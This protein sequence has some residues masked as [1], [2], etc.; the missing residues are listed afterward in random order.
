MTK[1]R[2]S[3]RESSEC[4]QLIHA[5]GLV[6]PLEGMMDPREAGAAMRVRFYLDESAQK[7][8]DN[9]N[10]ARVVRAGLCSGPSSS[11]YILKLCN[12]STIT[13][14]WAALQSIRSIPFLDSLLRA[15]TVNNSARCV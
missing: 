2:L 5:L 9:V 15:K 11:W 14:E 7:G 8:P 1:D 3:S 10:R 4:N 12:T 13:R 6:Q